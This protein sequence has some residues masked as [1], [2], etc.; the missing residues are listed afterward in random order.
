[1]LL[2]VLCWAMLRTGAWFICCGTWLSTI[3]TFGGA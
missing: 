3:D 2:I 1:M